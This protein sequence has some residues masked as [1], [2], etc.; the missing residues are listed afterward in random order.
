MILVVRQLKQ[1]VGVQILEV[2]PLEM[3]VVIIRLIIVLVQAVAM[4]QQ[5]QA[6]LT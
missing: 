4:V 5:R 6:E 3:L 2:Q 1:V